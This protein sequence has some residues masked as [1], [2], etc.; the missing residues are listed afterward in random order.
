MSLKEN[1]QIQTSGVAIG[2]QENAFRFK[3]WYQSLFGWQRALFIFLMVL[4]I[5]GYFAVRYGLELVLLRQYGQNALVAHPAFNNPEQLSQTKVTIVPNPN[6]TVS[7]YAIVKNPNL[8]LA[9]EELRYS[10]NFYNSRN[11][12]VYTS[13]G[14]AYILPNQSRWLVVPRVES[15][16]PISRSELVIDEPNWQK[17]LTVPEV[18]LRMNEPYTYQQDSPLATITEGS[19]INN[20]PYSLQQVSLVLVLYGENNQVLAMSSREEFTLQPYERRAYLLQWPGLNRS[21]VSRIGLEAYT[22]SL[23]PDNLTVRETP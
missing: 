14:V 20:S 19:V 23:D 10:F 5:P 8:D 12:Q 9:A 16:D 3:T 11:Q 7:A 15:T 22:N 21:S 1:L 2:V 4:L 17:R 13:S 6:G 18:E